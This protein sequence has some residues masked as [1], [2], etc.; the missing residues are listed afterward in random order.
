MTPRHPPRRRSRRRPGREASPTA[1]RLSRGRC[2]RAHRGRATAKGAPRWHPRSTADRGPEAALQRTALANWSLR[3]GR[4]ARAPQLRR[5]QDRA[6]ARLRRV[7]VSPRAVSVQWVRFGE[8]ASHRGRSQSTSVTACFAFMT[9]KAM[10]S[11]TRGHIDFEGRSPLHAPHESHAGSAFAISFRQYWPDDVRAPSLSPAHSRSS[12]SVMDYRSQ[13]QNSLGSA[14][15]R[16]LR[17]RQRHLALSSCHRGGAH[18]SR[19]IAG[20][21]DHAPVR[22][23]RGA[24]TH[25]T[26]IGDDGG[27]ATRARDRT[28]RRHQSYCCRRRLA[29]LKDVAGR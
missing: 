4:R 3:S 10:V 20:G 23:R 16:R 14:S 6:R 8:K 28:A 25:A 13:L 12:S 21:L 19:T 5:H 15:R 22:R 26:A 9:P 29:L 11:N 17:R 2:G 24:H 1:A 7:A 18:R 27:L